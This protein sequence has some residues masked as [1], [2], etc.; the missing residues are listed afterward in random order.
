MSTISSVIFGGSQRTPTITILGSGFGSTPA[1]AATPAG[2][3]ATGFDYGTSLFISDLSQ[4]FSAGLSNSVTN[5]S[6]GL[7]NLSYSDTSITF[8]LGSAYSLF[9]NNFKPGDTIG[10]GVNGTQYFTTVNFVPPLTTLTIGVARFFDTTNGTHFFTSDPSEVQQILATRKDLTEEGGGFNAVD[11]ASTGSNAAPVYRFFDSSY[12]TH[13][14][15][16]SVT[17]KNAVIASRAD[18]KYEGVALYE[19]AAQNPGDAAVYRFFDTKFG[20]HF[21]SSDATE[22]STILATRTD[23]KPEGIAFYAPT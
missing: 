17:E 15:T 20:T 21:Y 6:S 10:V 11:P 8:Q 23:L 3:G 19:D 22:I 1:S 13:F 4:N 18:L 9:L 12:G 16:S 2:S 7:T 5:N 14:F